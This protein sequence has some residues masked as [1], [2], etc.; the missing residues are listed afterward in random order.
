MWS[1]PRWLRT[2]TLSGHSRWGIVG[3]RIPLR[4][5]TYMQH[6]EPRAWPGFSL[7]RA[8]SRPIRANVRTPMNRTLRLHDQLDARRR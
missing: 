6:A 8:F 4:R 3:A 2:V 5:K 7:R 1:K